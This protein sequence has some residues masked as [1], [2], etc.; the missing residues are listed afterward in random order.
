VVLLSLVPAQRSAAVAA[1][2]EEGIRFLEDRVK[3]DPDDFIAQNQLASRYL[4]KLRETGD[5]TWLAAARRTAEKSLAIIPAERNLGGL[6]ALARV[7]LA[8]HR[9]PEAVDSAQKL[10]ALAPGKASSFTILGDALLE[11]GDRDQ[12]KAAYQEMERIA[13][14]SVETHSRRARLA[15]LWGDVVSARVQFLA[16]RS[17][18]KELVPEAPET[19][20]WCDVQLGELAFNR[21]DWAD[22]EQSYRAALEVFPDYFAAVD[23]LGELR[24]AR[25][26]YSGALALYEP[27]ATRLP[28]PEFFQVIGDVLAFQ[29]KLQAAKP[30]HD[31]ALAAYL[32]SVEQGEVHFFHHL[33]SFFSDVREEPAEAIKYARRDLDLRHT[34]G[35]HESLAWALYRGGEFDKSLA[36]TKL[37]LSCG[38]RSAHLSYHAAMIFSAAGDL[39]EGQRYLRETLALNPRYNTF[40]VHR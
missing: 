33:A 1:P 31:R 3:S 34:A 36:E 14:R 30:W 35:A 24:A 23:H 21:G 10:R 20:A 38:G 32:K 28:R 5:Y 17:A 2:I 9:F 27:L 37:A 8:A 26:D 29:G 4:E 18:A 16:A 12:A 13:P 6:A 40:H 19:V 39:K 11:Y 15:L 25:E 22:A 7:Q